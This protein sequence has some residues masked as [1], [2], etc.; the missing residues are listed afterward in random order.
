[1]VC[2]SPWGGKESDMAE[3]LNWTKLNPFSPFLWML[4]F[5]NHKGFSSS[6][7]TGFFNFLSGT[8][9]LSLRDVSA[10]YSESATPSGLFFCSLGYFKLSNYNPSK[11][12]VL[13]TFISSVQFSSVLEKKMVNHFSIVAFR[14]PWTVWRDIHTQVDKSFSIGSDFRLYCHNVLEEEI[15]LWQYAWSSHLW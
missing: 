2:C 5:I 1:M 8:S 7:S 15:D 12:S 11:A 14:T 3:R 13:E 9:R 4:S 10:M 6:D